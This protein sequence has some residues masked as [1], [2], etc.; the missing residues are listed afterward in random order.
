MKPGKRIVL[1]QGILVD[2]DQLL[3]LRRSCEPIRC[4]DH[5]SCCAVYEVCVS[6]KEVERITGMIPASARYAT[7]L[8]DG[9]SF[10]NPFDDLGGGETALETQE[11]G[12]CLFG[13]RAPDGALLC[14]IHSAALDLGLNPY[15]VKPFPCTLWPLALSE[16]KPPVL[17]VQEGVERFACIRISRRPCK[18]FSA[19]V[20]QTVEDCFGRA[21][22]KLLLRYEDGGSVSSTS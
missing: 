3:R 19:P 8:K 22:L 1:I 4:K 13:Y 5:Q 14:S 7:H 21:F 15:Q 2:L 9:R 20:L 11:D 17:G 10:E 16:G 12:T 6:R 18:R